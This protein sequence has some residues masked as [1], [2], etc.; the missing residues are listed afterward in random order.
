MELYSNAFG[1]GFLS[2]KPATDLIAIWT[3]RPLIP[4]LSP[5]FSAPASAYLKT[6]P[7]LGARV[8]LQGVS[9]ST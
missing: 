2:D 6:L 7:L 4:L 3:F 8:G 9:F 5:L 1:W